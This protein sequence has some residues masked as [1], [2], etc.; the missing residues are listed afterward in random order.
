MLGVVLSNW[1]RLI[2]AH[3]VAFAKLISN[4]FLPVALRTNNHCE[5]IPLDVYFIRYE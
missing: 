5:L 2:C 4:I 3:I 1:G